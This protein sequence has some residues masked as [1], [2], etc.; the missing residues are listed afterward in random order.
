M[1]EEKSLFEFNVDENS[2]REMLELSKWSKLFAILVFSLIGLAI[3]AIG[4]VWNTLAEK[5][6]EETGSSSTILAVTLAITG[7]VIIAIGGL[8]MFFLIRSSNRIKAGI[9]GHD[10]FLF[11]GGL[12]D[13]KTYF[14]FLGVFGILSLL[15][16]L[17]SLL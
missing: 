11:N 14:A 17:T 9:T 7:L 2:G 15:S 6:S 4:A 16:S 10:Q 12:N 1:E 13:L 5:F 8:M 3:L